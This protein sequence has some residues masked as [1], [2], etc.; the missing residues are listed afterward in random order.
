MQKVLTEVLRELCTR[1]SSPAV[2]GTNKCVTE[3]ISGR[4]LCPAI[5][6]HVFIRIG[7]LDDSASKKRKGLRRRGLV[8]G[9]KR[10]AAR[11]RQSRQS[12]FCLDDAP[13]QRTPTRQL[14]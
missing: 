12:L 5:E 1:R 4:L 8:A 6:L 13:A 9:R 3:D 2:G 14:G 10:T 7:T 11:F